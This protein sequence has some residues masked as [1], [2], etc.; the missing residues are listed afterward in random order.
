MAS[1][2]CPNGNKG[3]DKYEMLLVSSAMMWSSGGRNQ[4]GHRF[5]SL[6]RVMLVQ[7]KSP[8]T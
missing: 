5:C 3:S 8:F 6:S 2:D 7:T 4:Y 1:H